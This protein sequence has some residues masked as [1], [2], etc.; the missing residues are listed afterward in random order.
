MIHQYNNC[1][2]VGLLVGL[3]KRTILDK[4]YY[5]D[6]QFIH[7]SVDFVQTPACFRIYPA[8]AILSADSSYRPRVRYKP[9]PHGRAGMSAPCWRRRTR[10]S[11][12]MLTWHR[13]ISASTQ[14]CD[15]VCAMVW[16]SCLL[17]TSWPMQT[18]YC[19]CADVSPR[20]RRCSKK[21]LN[22][23]KFFIN[24]FFIGACWK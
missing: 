13:R 24:D 14:M 9:R 20:P 21:K 16:P 15:R 17:P 6:V 23:F 3:S 8:D 7:P 19:I 1:I 5:P 4:N 2:L 10:A 22:F 12:Q 18:G 11:V